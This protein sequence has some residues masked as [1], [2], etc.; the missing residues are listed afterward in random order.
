MGSPVL[1]KQQRVLVAACGS[2]TLFFWIFPPSW[3]HPK[4][5]CD[6]LQVLSAFAGVTSNLG[7]ADGIMFEG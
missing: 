1:Y 2:C 4:M 6:D 5:A 7:V 3:K